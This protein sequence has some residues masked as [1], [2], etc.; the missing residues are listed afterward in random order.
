MQFHSSSSELLE[1]LICHTSHNSLQI[2]VYVFPSLHIFPILS[3]KR[4]CNV[5]N[6]VMMNSLL[7]WLK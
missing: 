5:Q 6:M 4:S 2:L 7:F 1:Y 3:M